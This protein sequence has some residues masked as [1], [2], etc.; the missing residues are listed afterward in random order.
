[1]K[2]TLIVMAAVVAFATGASA[3]T[4]SIVSDKTTY[5]PGET[6]T[7][8]VFGDDQN[9]TPTFGSIYGN[10]LFDPNKVHGAQIDGPGGAWTEVIVGTGW[11]VGTQDCAPDGPCNSTVQLGNYPGHMKV[12]DQINFAGTGTGD[13]LT[14]SQAFATVTLIAGAVLGP[15]AINWD[16]AGT[17]GGV[18][19]FGMSPASAVGTSFSIVP[20]PEPTTAALLG[21]GLVGLVLGGRRRS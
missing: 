11:Q 7:L 12:F 14:G 2:R 6:I 10:I 4:L 18:S 16:V 8:T 15:V 3:A 1:M 13:G 19:F 20:I 5:N 9:A 17:A 21:L